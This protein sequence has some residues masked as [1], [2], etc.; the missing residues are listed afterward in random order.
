MTPHPDPAPLLEAIGITFGYD[1][2]PVLRDVSLSARPGEIV[3]LLGPNGCGKSTLLKVLL[4]QA[5]GAGTVR[6]D[7]RDIRQ[8]SQRDLARRVAFLPQHPGYTEGQSVLQAVAVGRYPHLGLLGLESAHDAQVAHE[9]AVSL[10]LEAEL[11]RPVES[12]SGGQRQRVFLARCLA[13]EPAALLLDEPDTFLDLRHAALLAGTLRRLAR[14]R[15]LT[16]VLASHD[17]HLAAALADRALL[18]DDG[19][20][21]AEGPP[22]AVLTPEHIARTY[23]VQA[24]PWQ[25]GAAWGV[26]VIY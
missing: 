24:V 13:Q 6:W 12:L 9:A 8:W 18:L 2:R 4:G 16:V 21:V 26:G 19:R 1:K 20:V 23:G 14:E 17:L 7:G 15:K 11:H 10:G 5:R 3:A 25:S 22:R